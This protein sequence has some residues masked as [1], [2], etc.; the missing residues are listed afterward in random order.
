M[1]CEVWVY[2]TH[3]GATTA[4]DIL[5]LF[6]LRGSS[7]ILSRL[8]SVGELVY[9]FEILLGT[10]MPALGVLG[11]LRSFGRNALCSGP[12]IIDEQRTRLNAER[13][14]QVQQPSELDPEVTIR[15]GHLWLLRRHRCI[16][17]V[18]TSEG[19]AQNVGR[20]V[21]YATVEK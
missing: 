15:L 4:T 14:G 5:A 3:G 2:V 17:T 21:W 11:V 12:S 1:A 13:Q 10:A 16:V 7:S 6:A 20:E 8:T 18:H 9:L 19:S